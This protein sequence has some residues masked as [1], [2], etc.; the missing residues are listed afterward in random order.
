MEKWLARNDVKG[1]TQKQNTINFRLVYFAQHNKYYS[2]HATIY[3]RFLSSDQIYLFI[4]CFYIVIP[5][6][7]QHQYFICCM[8]CT[9]RYIKYVYRNEYGDV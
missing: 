9:V 6:D 5:R 3:I 7:Y 2:Q 4:N 8:Y 1:N